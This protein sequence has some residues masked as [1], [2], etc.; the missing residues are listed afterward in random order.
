MSFAGDT[1]TGAAV[2]ASGSRTKIIDYVGP[3]NPCGGDRG[4][5]DDTRDQWIVGSAG[6]CVE[7]RADPGR[8][9]QGGRPG[10][11]MLPKFDDR[12]PADPAAGL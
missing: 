9:L 1:S 4:L 11:S 8:T 10:W 7:R 6:P 2:G 12:G 3:A 5:V